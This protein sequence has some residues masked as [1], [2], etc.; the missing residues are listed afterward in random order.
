MCYSMSTSNSIFF[1]LAFVLLFS[2]GKSIAEQG[3]VAERVNDQQ[4]IHLHQDV[5][6]S[7]T[8]SINFNNRILAIVN[9][10]PISMLDVVKQLDLL[11][12]RKYRDYQTKP[13]AKVQFYT[14]HWKEVFSELIDRELVLADAQ[15]KQ[16]TVSQG[17]VRQEMEEM[18]GPDLIKNV[19]EAGLT[20]PEV[21]KLLHADIT[22]RRMLFFKVR[23]KA[24][25]SISPQD[26]AAAYE[27]LKKEATVHEEVIWQV[28]SIK[29]D[30]KKSEKVACQLA[31]ELKP[32]DPPTKALNMVKDV[33][34]EGIQL[35]LS[36]PFTTAR[37]ALSKE[38]S[39]LFSSLKPQSYSAPIS[40]RGRDGAV[41]W[42]IYFLSGV[43]SCSFPPLQEVETQVREQLVAT[44]V[45]QMTKEYVVQ[46]HHHFGVDIEEINKALRGY[47]PF[48]VAIK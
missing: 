40:T 6:V 35:T 4:Q 45:E 1:L 48:K 8:N 11:F 18:F 13:E 32:S 28:I 30:P 33:E 3:S 37:K 25:A 41:S 20:I 39:T 10:T 38:L 31:K 12:Y 27:K 5:G 14:A 29:G 44:R 21:R 47:E 46:L 22:L 2:W 26:V 19:H 17:D 7:Q 43:Q 34:K 24:Y 16:F 23:A 9:G 15:E 36:A 42:K